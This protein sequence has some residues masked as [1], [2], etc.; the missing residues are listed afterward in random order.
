MQ[1]KVVLGRIEIWIERMIDDSV[2]SKAKM[3]HN[4]LFSHKDFA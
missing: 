3:F 1:K 2:F 4:S